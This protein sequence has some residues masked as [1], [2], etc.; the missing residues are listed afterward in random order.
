[1]ATEFKT[2]VGKGK[3]LLQFETDNK[4]YYLLMQAIARR[5]VDGGPITE[6]D[7]FRV[8]SNEELADW[9]KVQIG[10]GKGFFPCGD[11]CDSHCTAHNNEQCRAK[12]LDFLQR[13]AEVLPNGK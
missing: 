6:A 1:M 5:C 7:R 3:Y 4:E 2:R 9:A 8:M 12:I 10:C 13:P 11:V